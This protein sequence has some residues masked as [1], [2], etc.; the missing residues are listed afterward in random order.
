MNNNNRIYVIEAGWILTGK[1]TGR[2]EN[3]VFIEDAYVVRRW[4]NGLGIGGLAKAENKDDYTLDEI[5]AVYIR[6][7]KILFEIPCEW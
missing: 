5:G 2:D 7:N 4:S 1:E 3:G 6:A